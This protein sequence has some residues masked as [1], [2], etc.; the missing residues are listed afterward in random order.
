MRI[1]V[2]DGYTLNPGDNPWT[3]L[4]PLGSLTVHDRSAADEIVARAA[5]AEVVVV[6]KVKLP[7]AT[8]E[9]LPECR[10]ISVTATGFDI[11]DVKAARARGIPV[12]NV[13]EYGTD[14]VA[15][16]T[17]AM[18][19]ELCHRIGDHDRDVKAGGWVRCPDFSYWKSP[20]VE[21]A[22]KTFGVVGFGRIGRRTAEIAQALWMKVI[23]SSRSRSNP[24]SGGP[25]FAW[26]EVDEIFATAD[27]V[28]LH[29]PLT[30]ETRGLVNR[31][32]LGRMKASAFL[33][34]TSRGALMVE[35]DLVAA[36]REGKLAAA[37]I[38]VL[39]AEPMGAGH[40]YLA[41]TNLLLTPHNAWATLAARQRL[42][43]TT[44]DNIAAFASGE[45]IHVVN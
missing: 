19:L 11:V 10:F 27:V 4:E 2:L 13:P 31:E 41:A 21:L 28:S 20:L 25:G 23:A 7:A 17:I 5:G 14:S 24:L 36:L 18:L 22:G 40:P 29:C 15:Q 33:L 45:P 39:A 42:M 43:K 34:N 8:L 3:P 35:D 16:H 26:A 1:V 6:N 32:R 37:A 30:P 44:A 38:D 12:S 9:Q